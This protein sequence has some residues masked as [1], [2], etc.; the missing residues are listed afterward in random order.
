MEKFKPRGMKLHHG[1]FFAEDPG[2]GVAFCRAV[3]TKEVFVAMILSNAFRHLGAIAA[4]ALLAT[5]VG[6]NPV[7]AAGSDTPADDKKKDKKGSAIEEQEHQLAQAKA[8][9]EFVR[10]Y[11]AARDI[12]L[13]GQ[14]EK[15][16][17]AMHALGRD[18]NPD[19]ANYIG[20]ANRRMGNYEQSK[21]WYEAALKADPGHTRTWSYYGMW[22][23]EQGNRVKA[24]DYLT[25]VNALCGNTTCQEYVELKAVIDGTGT[26]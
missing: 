4:A 6:L 16:I 1:M 13:A 2:I 12:I 7:Y 23:A 18:S 8:Y 17:A 26:Y 24:R 22:Q 21:I 14:Y 11:R 3:Q 15:G 5:A 20:Y 25:K 9:D 19:V 10:G